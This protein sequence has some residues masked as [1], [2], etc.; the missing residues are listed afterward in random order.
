MNR[1]NYYHSTHLGDLGLALEHHWL[2]H[3]RH[4]APLHQGLFVRYTLW[5]YGIQQDVEEAAQMEYSYSVNN[6]VPVRASVPGTL[7]DGSANPKLPERNKE[8]GET[9]DGSGCL[10]PCLP[11]SSRNAMVSATLTYPSIPSEGSVGGRCIDD[12]HWRKVED[13]FP[14]EFCPDNVSLEELQDS[15][16]QHTL[17]IQNGR[18]VAATM[19]SEGFT[20]VSNVPSAVQ[21]F[22]DA[23]Q[24]EQ[25][26]LSQEIPTI[27]KKALATSGNTSTPAAVVPFHWLIRDS[28]R[29]NYDSSKGPVTFQGSSHA[30]V[31]RVHGDYTAEN[32]P[33]R[34]LELQKRGA[35]P[36]DWDPDIAHWGIV[37]IWKNVHDS[38]PIGKKPLALLDVQSVARSDVFQYWL[39]NGK[40]IGRN[41]AVGYNANHRWTYYPSLTRSEALAFFTWEQN[42]DSQRKVFHT[43]FDD[44]SIPSEGKHRVSIETRCLVVFDPKRKK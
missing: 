25:I 8:D 17:K 43:A 37:N 2:Y 40:R 13:I 5:F 3:R 15:S 21:D 18:L 9:F 1:T 38:E 7:P 24:V 33:L 39:V 26:Y 22:A 27:V 10:F 20:L 34:F 29:D 30:P 35:F 36:A 19:A 6:T 4:C 12:E 32:A 44:E 28:R 11:T 41:L 31:C 42:S 16:E 23:A 14:K